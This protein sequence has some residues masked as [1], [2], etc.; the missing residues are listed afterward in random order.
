MRRS[1]S[2]DGYTY[3]P[4]DINKTIFV[5]IPKCAGVSVNKALFGNLGGGHTSL[6]GYTMV[7]EPKYLAEYFKFTVVRNPWDRLV[8]TYFFLK[9]GGFGENDRRWF[10]QELMEFKD[11]DDF[12][13]NWLNRNNIWKT[14]LFRPQYH[15]M[16]EYRNKVNLDFV[17]FFENIDEDFSYI[18]KRIGCNSSLPNLNSSKHTPYT[19]YYNEVTTN[20]VAEAYAED[21][22][23]LGYD[24][25]NS[26]IQKQLTNRSPQEIYARRS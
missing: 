18:A 15:Y 16:F 10:E 14:H 21:I 2:Q 3:E 12:V 24:F 7:F 26:N 22:K 11:F 1:V 4:F 19:D 17:A 25:D 23:M 20:I 8:S 5:H 9:K 6:N 13:K